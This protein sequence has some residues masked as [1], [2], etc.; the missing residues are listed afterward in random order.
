MYASN[1]LLMLFCLFLL[2][3]F[4][5]GEAGVSHSE[6]KRRQNSIKSE[7]NS[8]FYLLSHFEIKITMF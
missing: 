6:K 4:Q 1:S 7:I 5:G 2:S 3:S 8:S